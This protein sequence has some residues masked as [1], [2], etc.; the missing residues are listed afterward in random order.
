M[1]QFLRNPLLHPP[2][3]GAAGRT[4]LKKR[5]GENCIEMLPGEKAPGAHHKSSGQSKP[6]PRV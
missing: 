1:L 4:A 3:A 6:D 5:P 2:K